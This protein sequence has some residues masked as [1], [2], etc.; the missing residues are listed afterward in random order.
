MYAGHR[1][2]VKIGREGKL[3]EGAERHD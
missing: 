3:T 1:N 2:H